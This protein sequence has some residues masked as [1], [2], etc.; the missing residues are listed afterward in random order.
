M[1]VP[2]LYFKHIGGLVTWVKMSVSFE[3]LMINMSMYKI[4]AD[5]VYSLLSLTK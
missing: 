4:L 5:Y 2:E 3:S 1:F